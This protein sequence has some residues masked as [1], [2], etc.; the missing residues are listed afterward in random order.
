MI[1]TSDSLNTNLGMHLSFNILKGILV[2][3]LFFPSIAKS[4]VLTVIILQYAERLRASASSSMSV[5]LAWIHTFL[6]SS[7][8]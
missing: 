7:I 3:F 1:C 5:S 8:N 4:P 2:E 6:R